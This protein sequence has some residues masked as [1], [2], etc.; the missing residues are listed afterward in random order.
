MNLKIMQGDQYAI[1]FT[2]TQDGKTLSWYGKGT[3]ATNQLNA[4]GYTYR[5]IA[6]R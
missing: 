2:G 6:W 3:V 4:N 5:V 1:V